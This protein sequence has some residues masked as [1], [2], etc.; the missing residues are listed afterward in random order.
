MNFTIDSNLSSLGFEQ[1]FGENYDDA[2]VDGVPYPHIGPG[3]TFLYL[4]NVTDIGNYGQPNPSNVAP[5]Y[6]SFQVDVNPGAFLKIQPGGFVGYVPQYEY[7]PYRALGGGEA[8]IDPGA[9]GGVGGL[10]P[11]TLAQFGL[12]IV[13]GVGAGVTEVSPGVFVEQKF[14]DFENADLGWAN[15]YNLT[16]TFGSLSTQTPDGGAP[17]PW[18]GVGNNYGGFDNT[19]FGMS[20][21]EDLWSSAIQLAAGITGIPTPIGANFG[22]LNNPT[23][24]ATGA[25]NPYGPAN[26]PITYDPMTQILT[27][28]VNNRIVFVDDGTIYDITTFGQIVAHGVVVPEPASIAMLACGAIGLVGYAVRRKRKG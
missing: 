27:I 24:N 6:G 14:V 16:Q 11:G 13:G 3:D 22:G 18:L 28:P 2:G 20:G 4:G 10:G 26:G 21:T 8:S 15:I 9:T 19:L 1:Y 17:M 5:A 12:S 25:P 23:S 7:L